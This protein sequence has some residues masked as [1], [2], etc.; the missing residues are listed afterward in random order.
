M[1]GCEIIRHFVSWERELDLSKSQ[2]IFMEISWWPCN[3][4]PLLFLVGCSSL[5]SPSSS[6]RKFAYNW[7]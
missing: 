6:L 3:M 1:Q 4:Q 7:F 2:L 5:V